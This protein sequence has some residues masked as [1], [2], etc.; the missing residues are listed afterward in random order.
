[1]E[2]NV[3]GEVRLELRDLPPACLADDVWPASVAASLGALIT[4]SKVQGAVRL[5]RVEPRAQLARYTMAWA[6][7]RPR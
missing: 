6:P 4:V 1:V 2:R 7:A 3:P 5:D